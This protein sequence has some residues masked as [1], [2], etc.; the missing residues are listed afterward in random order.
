MKLEIR[1]IGKMR[2]PLMALSA[3]YAKRVGKALTLREYEAPRGLTGAALLKKEAAFLLNDLPAL[4]II[5]LDERG[6]DDS[7]VAWAQHLARWC[8]Q[9]G[10]VFLLGGPDGHA[11]E[12]RDRADHVVAFGQKTWPHLLAR[13]MLIEQI[14][15]AQQIVAGHPYHRS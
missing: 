6:R 7:S 8:D 10:A 13:V 2:G 4:P 1:A 15:R 14:Y 9:G 3:E 5:V 12:V 11:A